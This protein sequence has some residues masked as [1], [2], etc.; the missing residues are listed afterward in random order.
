[1]SCFKT[2]IKQKTIILKV[3]NAVGAALAQVSGSFSKTLTNKTREEA[4]TE[5]KAMAI[6][7][8]YSAGAIRDSIQIV[9]I[10]EIP[11]SYLPGTYVPLLNDS[12]PLLL[13][14][15]MSWL[16]RLITNHS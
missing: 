6:D 2:S 9:D 10:V 12:N 4:L 7:S 15:V 11:L 14:V 3:A 8:A 1:M 13:L 16:N 5:A